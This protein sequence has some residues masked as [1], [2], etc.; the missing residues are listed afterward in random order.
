VIFKL[1]DIIRSDLTNH[2]YRI[3]TI[4][5]ESFYLI[6]TD[7]TYKGSTNY[8]KEFIY[9]NFKLVTPLEQLL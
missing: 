7:G 6:N 9:R 1:G 4:E 5:G 2:V 8:S 3:G